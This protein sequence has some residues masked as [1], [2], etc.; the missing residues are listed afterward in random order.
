MSETSSL[1]GGSKAS[2]A[3]IAHSSDEEVGHSHGANGSGAHS[4]SSHGHSHGG[5]SPDVRLSPR[6]AYAR[7]DAEASKRAHDAKKLH[8]E[9]H[10]D[11]GEYIKSIVYGGLDGII[12]TFA[13]VTSVAGADFSAA[14][15]VVLGISHLFADGLSM[16]MGDYLSSEAEIDYT[17]SERKREAWEMEVNMKGEIEEMID[18]YIAKGV[19]ETDARIIINTLAKYPEAFL[20]HMMVEELGLLPPEADQGFSPAKAGMVTMASFMAFGSVPLLPYLIALIPGLHMS[21]KAQLW[22]S[23]VATIFTLFMLGAFK[24][25][26]VEIKKS[27]WWRSGL[28]MAFNGTMAAVVGYA[29]GWAISQLMELPP[30][31]G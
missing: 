9:G 1:K 16:G 2:Y 13:T 12:T 20:D 10:S 17:A 5:R 18:L 15:I 24:G 14:V 3:A 29:I 26:T 30:G 7:G 19:S 28:L 11:S 8:E 22:A 27:A 31:A 25:K 21:A 6:S 4:H 23:V